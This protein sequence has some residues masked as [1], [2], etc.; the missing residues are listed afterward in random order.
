MDLTYAHRGDYL[1]SLS[2]SKFN[3]A[4]LVASRNVDAQHAASIIRFDG[5][6]PVW[7]IKADTGVFA[8]LPVLGTGQKFA[9]KSVTYGKLPEH[10]A[11]A[12]PDSGPPEPLEA[13]HYYI[14]TAQRA[15]GTL[16]YEAVRV[17]PDG[18]LDGYEAEPR[19][20]TSYM[21]CCNVNPDFV[22]PT[23]PVTPGGTGPP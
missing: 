17:E 22:Q 14:F 16:S 20:G 13:G 3:G 7:E 8:K 10:F 23:A 9:V 12:T 11:Q 2:V 1:A 15:T 18:S 19:A 5:G 6:V 4:E 21:L